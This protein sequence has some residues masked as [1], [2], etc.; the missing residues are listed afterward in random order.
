MNDSQRS[1]DSQWNNKELSELIKEIEQKAS[2]RNQPRGGVN[3]WRICWIHYWNNEGQPNQKLHSRNFDYKFED[4]NKIKPQ[5]EA[6]DWWYETNER[7]K[8]TLFT[9]ELEWKDFKEKGVYPLKHLTNWIQLT[10]GER[11]EIEKECWDSHKQQW[12]REKLMTYTLKKIK[13]QVVFVKLFL[14][15]VLDLA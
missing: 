7:L 9:S 2:I 1:N 12:Y 14:N 3:D 5:T 8:K 15:T 4:R 11:T 13:N 6:C 10:A